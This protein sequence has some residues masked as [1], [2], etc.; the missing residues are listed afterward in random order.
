MSWR[1]MLLKSD[2]MP[3]TRLVLH[4][5]GCHM[6]DAGESC[7]PSIELLCAETGLSNRSVITHL[8]IAIERGFI[9]VEKHGFKGQRWARNEY[10]ISWPKVVQEVHHL[11]NEGS[12]PDDIKA[13]K[14]V[15]TNSPVNSPVLVT[16]VTNPPLAPSKQS[17]ITFDT[18]EGIFTNISKAV[19]DR[20]Q[21]AYPKL[22]I[23]AELTRAELWYVSNPRKRK[24]DHARFIANWL[25]QAH[26][27]SVTPR[28]FTKKPGGNDHGKQ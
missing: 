4:T 10:R 27:R 19:M 20:W 11:I 26:E 25:A 23:D 14:E 22:D 6:N 1:Q 13:V 21:E 18:S 24:R 3:V 2:L 9:V 28:T 17:K 7:Y 5:L 12:E 16:N 15:H 8:Q